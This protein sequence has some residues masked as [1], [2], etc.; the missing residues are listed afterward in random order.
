M[1]PVKGFSLIELM[2]VSAIFVFLLGAILG[3][4]SFSNVSWQNGSSKMTLSHELRRGM[5]AMGRD[6]SQAKASTISIAPGGSSSSVSFQMARDLNNDGSILLSNGILEGLQPADPYV[7]Y[8]S[9]FNAAAG[10]N[11]LIKTSNG[12]TSVLAN[13]L[14]GLQFTRDLSSP[15]ILHISLSGEKSSI[16]GH[17]V[18]GS[19]NGRLLLRN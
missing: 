19:L 4:I 1:R 3:F 13:Y 14:D 5:E 10:F 9:V 8:S 15:D 11:Q 7:T 6:L 2:A 18:E 12:S 17:L 16:S